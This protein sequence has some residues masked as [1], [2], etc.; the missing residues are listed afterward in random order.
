MGRYVFTPEIFEYIDRTGEGKGGEIQLTDAIRMYNRDS[1]VYA[2]E[3]I[4]QRFDLGNKLDWLRTNV[5]AALRRD[6]FR[7]DMLMFLRNTVADTA[8][9]DKDM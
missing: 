9:D 7:D 6:E 4:G 2:Y 8:A 5:E 1:E 3:F